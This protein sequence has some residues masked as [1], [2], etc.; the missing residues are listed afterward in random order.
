M[1]T[2]KAAARCGRTVTAGACIG[3][4]VAGC[5]AA[6]QRGTASRAAHATVSSPAAPA[7]PASSREFADLIDLSQ[8]LALVGLGTGPQVGGSA[9]L[10]ASSDF[11]RSFTAIGPRTAAV[12]VTDDVFFVNRADGW[13]AVFNED[14]VRETLY[15]TRDGGHSWQAFSA[16]SH[17]VAGG[18]VDTVQFL[19]PSEGW[20][21][22]TM[23]TA[24]REGLFMTRDGG[25]SWHLMASAPSGRLPALGPVEFEPGG[26]IG[27]LGGG[28]FSN[29]LYRTSDQGRAWH[30]AAIP[31]P[32][33]S[34]FGLPA[35]LDGTL[36]EPVVTGSTHELRLYRSTDGGARW[37]LV[38]TL[39]AVAVIPG[40]CGPAL[41]SASFPSRTVA[42]AAAAQGR[43]TVVYRTTDQGRHWTAIK[44]PG[45]TP[46]DTCQA[47]Q[48]QALDATHA[49]LLD[50]GSGR[51]YA[52]SDGGSIWR[53]I[54][55]A[56]LAAG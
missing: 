13:F 40:T 1:S 41:V 22:Q 8:R 43:R 26:H 29:A 11:G 37:S 42:W 18:A 28:I 2:R 52:T 27:W 24:P 46:A 45:T 21:T 10:V 51:I 12:T 9:R 25:R 17:N 55:A 36:L 3:A 19:T 20:L 5:G 23:P 31:A 16:P 44:V 49:W 47:P 56:A 50:R 4:L 30:R 15:R 32:A 14:T 34:W 35:L 48:L 38:S 53:R 6:A 33:G 7:T 54:D 39:P